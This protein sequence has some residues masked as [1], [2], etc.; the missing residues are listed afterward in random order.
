M[1]DKRAEILEWLEGQDKLCAAAEFGPWTFSTW[2][3]RGGYERRMVGNARGTG[4]IVRSQHLSHRDG[5]FIAASRAG[6]PKALA[7][8]RGEVEAHHP[9]DG[10][11]AECPATGFC[12]DP[13][14]MEDC[15]VIER[16]H[17]ATV[18]AK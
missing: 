13:T 14:P 10:A 11:C 15:P 18:G 16:I 1:S 12:E 8:L 5:E 17:A 7:A 9:R 4:Q 6:Y 2:T 3:P